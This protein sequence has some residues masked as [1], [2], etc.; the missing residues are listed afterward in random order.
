MQNC[1]KCDHTL[2]D[3]DKFCANCG[4]FV[5]EKHKTKK[6]I[7]V[8]IFMFI[9]ALIIGFMKDA[10]RNNKTTE[11][12][13]EPAVKTNEEYAKIF[14]DRKLEDISDLEIKTGLEVRE[15]ATVDES[16]VIR[17]M[18]FAYNNSYDTI[19]YI[20]ETSYFPIADFDDDI[21]MDLG[22]DLKNETK[23]LGQLDFVD[24]THEI[25]KKY[26]VLKIKYDY[27]D[28][29]LHLSALYPLSKI[30]GE[31]WGDRNG[32]VSARIT[33]DRLKKAGYVLK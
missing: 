32:Y 17:K 6:V 8:F 20:V 28:D 33:K 11:I 1:P 24:I 21:I 4:N 27:L 16:D 31:Y 19:I 18:E 9:G 15:Y 10:W 12:L 30:N 22:N 5:R 13:E 26:Y 23:E 2:M 29:S 7:F 3:T 25:G 14:S